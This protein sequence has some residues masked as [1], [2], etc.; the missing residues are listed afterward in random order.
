MYLDLE[1]PASSTGQQ[2][3]YAGAVVTD[4]GSFALLMTFPNDERW[5]NLPAVLVTAWSSGT[6]RK[7]SAEFTLSANAA[8]PGITSTPD[9]TQTPGTGSTPTSQPV[10]TGTS[11]VG[12]D[13]IGVVTTA[14]LNVRQGPSVAYPV[15]DTLPEGSSFEV[16]GQNGSGDWLRVVMAD[17]REGWL[18]RGFTDYLASAPV[19]S[20]PP[21]P[22]PVPTSTPVPTSVPIVIDA[23]RGEYFAGRELQGAPEL[24]RNDNDLDFT[25]GNGAPAAALPADGF[26]ARWTRT[27]T[28]SE[29]TYRFYARSDDGVRAWL[30]GQLIVDQW[31]DGLSTTFFAERSLGSGLHTLR[32]EYYENM[33]SASLQF[34]W[35]RLAVFPQWRGEYYPNP[36]LSG[37]PT[38]VRNDLAV[39]FN[40]GRGV[41]ASGLP[42]DNFSVWWTWTLSFD[43]GLYRLHA[44]VDDGVRVYVDGTLVIDDWRD[45]GRRRS[46]AII[47][48]AV[49]TITCVSNTTSV[50][51]DAFI[52]VWWEQV[53]TYPDWRGAYWS[54]SGLEGNPTLVRNEGAID[55]DWERLTGKRSAGRSFL[56][57]VDVLCEPGRV[58][59]TAST[60]WWMTAPVCGSTTS[61]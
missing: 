59:P 31:R 26:S 19:V 14:N 48:W 11:P 53:S 1:D 30:D 61:C 32:V 16:T 22:A 12:R 9:V 17:G 56:C 39:D 3:A 29:G 21:L 44:T 54:N 41:P 28:F 8:T 43:E 36:T 20:A 57:G 27:L 2:T 40:W 46:P 25:W 47:S 60:C 24:V 33:G 5:A 6:G 51:A 13:N 35:E 37:N 34:W 23:W 50:L 10:A 18:Y 4:D 38:V 58:T 42:A 55:F 52:H 49:A 7:V 15:V 45:G